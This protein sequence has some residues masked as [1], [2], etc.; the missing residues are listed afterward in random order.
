MS[1]ERKDREKNRFERNFEEVQEELRQLFMKKPELREALEI[2]LLNAVET[3]LQ[4]LRP[5]LT[6][7]LDE[8]FNGK[9]WPKSVEDWS[10]VLLI[11][12]DGKYFKKDETGI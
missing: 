7:G 8:E 11:P 6:K 5:S 12:I 4:T 3:G 2:T 1:G 9:A 10:G